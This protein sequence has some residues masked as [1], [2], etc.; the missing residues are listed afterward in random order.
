MLLKLRQ[1]FFKGKEYSREK[2][3][4][5]GQHNTH[6]KKT[7]THTHE[8]NPYYFCYLVSFSSKISY[9]FL[10]IFTIDSIV[11]LS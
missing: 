10:T 9:Y 5:N 8:K 4:D 1:F 2:T 7:H 3:T 6:T 11:C